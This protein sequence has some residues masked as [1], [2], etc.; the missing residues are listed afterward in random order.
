M[1]IASVF[2]N[3]EGPCDSF[4]TASLAMSIWCCSFPLPQP[5]GHRAKYRVMDNPVAHWGV[6]SP[7]KGKPFWPPSS[8]PEVIDSPEPSFYPCHWSLPSGYSR[9]HHSY[10]FKLTHTYTHTQRCWGLRSVWLH[11]W[12]EKEG[13]G[14]REIGLREKNKQKRRKIITVR[15]LL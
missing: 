13:T 2:R 8:K 6:W 10:H 1:I 5:S 14:K 11:V 4:R 3:P 12:K 9:W 7:M 15:T